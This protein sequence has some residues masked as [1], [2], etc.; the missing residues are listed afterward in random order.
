MD[1]SMGGPGMASLPSS[2]MSR[3]FSKQTTPGADFFKKT[4]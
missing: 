1:E 3:E 4:A 2:S